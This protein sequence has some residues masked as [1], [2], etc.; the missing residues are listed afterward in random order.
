MSGGSRLWRFLCGL[1]GTVQARRRR[2]SR[3]EN[4]SSFAYACWAGR[5]SVLGFAMTTARFKL[6]HRA[7]CCQRVYL[8]PRPRFDATQRRDSSSLSFVSPAVV[9]PGLALSSSFEITDMLRSN[10][11]S[12]SDRGQPGIRWHDARTTA[13]HLPFPSLPSQAVLETRCFQSSGR[14]RSNYSVIELLA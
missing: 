6:P 9:V 3:G 2:R 12:E 1:C 5:S 8:D 7:G 14:K 10:Q 11:S 4:M 13:A